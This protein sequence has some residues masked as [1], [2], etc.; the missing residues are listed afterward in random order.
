M[1]FKVEGDATEVPEAD[2][3][4]QEQLKRRALFTKHL[5]GAAEGSAASEE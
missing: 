3:V 1:C 5:S 2:D 4:V